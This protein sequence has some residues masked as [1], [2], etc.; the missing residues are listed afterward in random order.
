MLLVR[1][2]FFVVSKGDFYFQGDAVVL[3]SVLWNCLSG[4]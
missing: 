1:M 3:K 2:G 4:E